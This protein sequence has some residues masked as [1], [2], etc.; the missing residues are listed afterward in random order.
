[1]E[2]LSFLIIIFLSLVGY[3]GGAVIRTERFI[4]LKPEI[5]DLILVTTIWTAVI[6]SRISLNFNKWFLIVVWV[7]LSGIVG[8]L[9]YFFRD[10]PEKRNL[11]KKKLE[12]QPVPIFKKLWNNWKNF[13]KEMGSFQ[14]RIILSL[15][16]FI[17][18][19]PFALVVKIFLNPLKIKYKGSKSYWIP[20][21]EIPESL[22]R[23]KRQF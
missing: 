1:M 14:S 18:V 20:K 3:C 2:I 11:G 15:F 19:L 7:V 23:Y 10:L 9:T 16:F 8:K 4:D 13:S 17:F 21:K 6:Y 22:D 12:N 5:Y